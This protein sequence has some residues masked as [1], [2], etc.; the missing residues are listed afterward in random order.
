[1]AVK[2]FRIDEFHGI[3][4]SRDTLN[5]VDIN[6]AERDDV[7]ADLRKSHGSPP[8]NA[9]LPRDAGDGRNVGATQRRRLQAD[10]AM[11]VHTDMFSATAVSSDH[12]IE[13]RDAGRDSLHQ[14]CVSGPRLLGDC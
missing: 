9:L 12:S 13:R 7:I 6:L 10:R 8:A 11:Q 3:D 5:E 1:M 2:I 14:C 4:Q